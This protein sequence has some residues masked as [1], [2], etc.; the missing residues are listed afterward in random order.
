[1]EWEEAKDVE[2]GIPKENHSG[3]FLG[4]NT[5]ATYMKRTQIKKTEKYGGF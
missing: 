1:M 4:I 5:G 2:F 3:S